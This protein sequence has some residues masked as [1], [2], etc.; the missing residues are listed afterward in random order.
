VNHYTYA[1]LALDIARERSAEAER[2]Y[3]A[4]Q[5][6]A[7]VPARSSTIRRLAARL[8]AAFSRGSASVVR[9]LDDCV[10]DELGRSLAP[11]E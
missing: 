9:R 2:D 3:L 7:A 6:A 10:A 8:L 1:I 5:L 4:S 11:A